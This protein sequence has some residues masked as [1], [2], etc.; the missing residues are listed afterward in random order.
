MELALASGQDW[1][2]DFWP[3]TTGAST[4]TFSN[5]M[6]ASTT[7]SP[8]MLQQEQ[9]PLGQAT[10]EQQQQ[11]Q[12]HQHQQPPPAMRTVGTGLTLGRLDLLGQKVV[13]AS[14]STSTASTTNTYT[15]QPSPSPGRSTDTKRRGSDT[16]RKDRS[17][18]LKAYLMDVGCT[19]IRGARKRRKNDEGEFEGGKVDWDSEWV[20][21]VCMCGE[22][23]RERACGWR[24]SNCG[25]AA[26][27]SLIPC[28]TQIYDYSPYFSRI[29]SCLLTYSNSSFPWKSSTPFAWTTSAAQRR[30]S[31]RMLRKN[32]H[33]FA[34]H[35][36][37]GGNDYGPHF[38]CV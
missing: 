2:A 14:S 26:C 11:H 10:F 37:E 31:L 32:R 22:G 36:P 17:N 5:I 25:A 28:L 21:E 38:F 9:Y 30:R 20:Q 12:H 3:L 33:F 6:G 15:P 27:S 4:D 1:A 8:G 19:K 34:I 23:E 7:S 35:L 18:V 13:A 29:S 24:V 16:A